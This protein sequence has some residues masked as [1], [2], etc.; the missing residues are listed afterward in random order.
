MYCASCQYDSSV[1]IPISLQ[2]SSYLQRTLFISVANF[3]IIKMDIIYK[4]ETL[5]MDGF[6]DSSYLSSNFLFQVLAM[7]SVI[8]YDIY[9]TYISPFRPTPVPDTKQISVRM[10][11][12]I[13]NEEYLEYDK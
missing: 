5:W 2:K 7:S 9:Q 1:K 12:A 13:K 6:F 3:G 4:Q 8:I 10:Q 11:R